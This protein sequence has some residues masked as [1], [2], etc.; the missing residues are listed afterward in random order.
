MKNLNVAGLHLWAIDLSNS[1]TRLWVTT[2]KYCA[3][4]ASKKAVRFLRNRKR[5]YPHVKVEGLEY[6][7][8]LDA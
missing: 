7:G 1:I 8:T 4:D 2:S 3:A 6:H 5:R